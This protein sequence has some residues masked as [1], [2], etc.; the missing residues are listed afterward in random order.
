LYF[1]REL[2]EVLAG[3]LDP[4]DGPRLSDHRPVTKLLKKCSHI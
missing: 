1:L 3:A 4:R 2:L